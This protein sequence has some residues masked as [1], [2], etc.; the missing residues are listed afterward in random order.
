MAHTRCSDNK[1]P[2]SESL[3]LPSPVILAY[4]AFSPGLDG[5][6]WYFWDH[7]VMRLVSATEHATLKIKLLPSRPNTEKWMDALGVPVPLH[8]LVSTIR[9]TVV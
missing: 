2:G 9:Y 6:S 7:A 8:E 1:H 5:P 3:P 4:S